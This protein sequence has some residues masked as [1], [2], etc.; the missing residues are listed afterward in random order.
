MKFAYC[1][2]V[3]TLGIKTVATPTYVTGIANCKYTWHQI[4][5]CTYS[6]GQDNLHFVTLT[7]YVKSNLALLG[8][9]KLLFWSFWRF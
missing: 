2:I 4:C 3:G 8:D 6:R 1:E 9:M 5:W 7:F